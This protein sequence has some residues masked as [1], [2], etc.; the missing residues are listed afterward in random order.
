MPEARLDPRIVQHLSTKLGVKE[1]TIREDIS[2]LRGSYLKCTANAVAQ[3]YAKGKGQTVARF[4][5]PD[6]KHSLPDEVVAERVKIKVVERAK[7]SKETIK[8]FLQFESDDYFIK[9]H[10]FETN[11]AYHYHCYTAVYILSRKIIENL[12]IDALKQ[13][14]PEKSRENKELYWSIEKKRFKDLSVILDTLWEKRNDFGPTKS[15]AI[16]RLVPMAR[17]FKDEAND[18]THSWFHLV[19]RPRELDDLQLQEMLEL[20]KKILQP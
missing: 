15:K 7:K 1:K 8:E 4:L 18:K 17:N 19:K 3:L 20:L 6:D 2:R 10:L 14:F 16:G 12:I 13:Q 5:K 11:R 9:G